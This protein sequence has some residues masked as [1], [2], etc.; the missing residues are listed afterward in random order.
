MMSPLWWKK[1]NEVDQTIRKWACPLYNSLVQGQLHD[2]KQQPGGWLATIILADQFPRNMFRG[3][4]RSF[5]RDELALSLALEGIEKGVDRQ[6]RWP[7]RVFFY[8]PLEHSESPEMQELSVQQ[9]TALAGD[10]PG[11]EQ[12]LVYGYIDFAIKH[13]EIIN[14]FGRFPHRNGIL[15]RESTDEELEFLKLPGS[16]F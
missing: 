3:T 8:M 2:W 4:A 15:G 13:R 11:E 6:L 14:R 7:E 10:V 12:D 5:E 1:N 9:F 16:S